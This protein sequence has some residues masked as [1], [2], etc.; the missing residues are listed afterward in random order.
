MASKQPGPKKK[1]KSKQSSKA[2]Q[3]VPTAPVLE[4]EELSP[5]PPLLTEDLVD[6]IVYTT[7]MRKLCTIKAYRGWRLCDLKDGIWA[8]CGIEQIAQKLVVS[9][10]KEMSEKTLLADFSPPS[11]QGAAV[12]LHRRSTEQAEWLQRCREYGLQLEFAPQTIKADYEVVMAAVMKNPKAIQFAAPELR[13][14]KEI[15]LVAIKQDIDTADF[16]DPG[17]WQNRDFVIQAVRVDWQLLRMACEEF[18]RDPEIVLAAI[19]G[20]W[21]AVSA[22]AP[23]AWEYMPVP[24]AAAV[25]GGWTVHNVAPHYLQARLRADKEFALHC[26]RLDWRNLEKIDE[27]L[28]ADFDIA[29]AA[30]RQDW[31]ALRWIHKDLQ[32]HEEIVTVA[33]EHNFLCITKSLDELPI[34][35]PLVLRIV[36]QNWEA[37]AHLN[38]ELR[39]DKE[40]ANAAIS[41][42][43]RAL[44]FAGEAR[45]NDPEIVGLA[46]RQDPRAVMKAPLM[47]GH[48]G[49]MSIVVAADGMLLE[50]AF[51]EV[52]EDPSIVKIAVRQNWQALQFA[53]EPVRGMK[54]VVFPALKND[55]SLTVM[56][57]T[58]PSLRRD[59]AAMLEFL[60]HD[61]AIFP[62]VDDE[63]MVHERFIYN[64]SHDSKLGR[65][66][67]IQMCK[68]NWKCFEYV[69]DFLKADP[70]VILTAA[71][72]DWHAIEIAEDFY[73]CWMHPKIVLA[74]VSQ[75]YTNIRNVNSTMWDNLEIV[76]AAVSQNWRILEEAP[77]FLMRRLWSEEEVVRAA[78]EQEPS[79]IKKAAKP[80]WGERSLVLKACQGDW[81]IME[82][83]PKELERIYW[84]D[85]DFV[86]AA[87][88]QSIDALKKVPESYW[89]DKEVMRVAVKTDYKVIYK[90]SNWAQKTLW[91]DREIVLHAVQQNGLVLTEADEDFIY[92]VEVLQAAVKQNWTLL[93]NLSKVHKQVAWNDETCARS[94]IIDGSTAVVADPSNFAKVGPKLKSNK[95]FVIEVVSLA[96]KCLEFAPEKLKDDE[97]VVRAAIQSKASKGLAI[98]FA[99]ERLRADFQMAQL[100][101]QQDPGAIQFVDESLRQGHVLVDPSSSS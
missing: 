98:Q 95:D 65:K 1:L 46:C 41:Q 51:E 3:K 75:D 92:D 20:N 48:K 17:V 55:P 80:L 49:V 76:V 59:P 11:V 67:V 30:V 61:K 45:K 7:T 9:G 91:E 32:A 23:E 50:K 56:D 68:R 94:A 21:D 93:D 36:Q 26:V 96:G 15:M 24:R 42:N 78:V 37:F 52:K 2:L 72:Q 90:C 71:Q 19:E 29:L 79:V 28:L 34:E 35:Q 31:R 27:K 47:L 12:I 57:W 73:D 70:E 101:V 25:T 86:V 18:L 6:V 43:W 5:R 87:L 58:A 13:S 22:A 33:V 38:E 44:E 89:E 63:L 60:Q 69:P 66:I 10:H 8:E 84:K 14:N 85:K 62:W 54:D 82:K 100:A 64:V 81:T 4:I 88:S 74:A 99:S 40:I 83:C 97:D 16:L 77:D 39:S 53:S